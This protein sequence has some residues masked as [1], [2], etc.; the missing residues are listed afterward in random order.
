MTISKIE[1][2]DLLDKTIS[3]NFTDVFI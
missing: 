2:E 3:I 1:K